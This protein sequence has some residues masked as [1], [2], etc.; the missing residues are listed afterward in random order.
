M[1]IRSKILFV[2]DNEGFQRNFIPILAEGEDFD[3]FSALSGKR[4]LELLEIENFDVIVSDIQMPEMSGIEFLQQIMKLGLDIPV[5]FVTAYG[6][7]EQAI[8]LVKQGAF[9]YFE[10][11]LI[12]K[13]DILKATIR[14]ALSKGSMLKELAT[15]RREKSLLSRSR[16]TIIGQSERIKN[17]LEAIEEVASTSVNVLIYG[18]TGTGK[19]LVARMIHDLSERRERPFFPISCTEIPEGLLESELFGHERGAFTGAVSRQEGLLEMADQSTFFLDEISEASPTLQSKLLRAVESKTF[20]RVGGRTQ[21]Q[22]D[23]RLITATNRDLE[24]RVAAGSFRQDLFYRLNTYR[25]NLPSLRERKSDIPLLVEYYLEK[26]R[27]KYQRPITDISGDAMLF[28]MEYGWPGNIRELVSLMERAVITCRG[29]MI[30]LDHFP[31]KNGN[32]AKRFCESSDLNLKEMERFV[33]G[34]ALKRTEGNKVKAAELLGINRK[35]L[36]EKMKSYELD[37][38][39]KDS[40]S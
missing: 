39:A 40:F 4:A 16:S 18:E 36:A 26:F 29:G 32:G 17:V 23:F 14:Q 37:E 2:E 21:I 7:V 12:N 8:E 30:T 34:M 3:I 11:P 10:K 1:A 19:D 27:R 13:I 38:S 5:I 28:L 6:S 15:F 24:E 22:S 25:I 20:F 35:T 33:I 9:H 31:F